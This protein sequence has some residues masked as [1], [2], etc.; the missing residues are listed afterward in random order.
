MPNDSIQRADRRAVLLGVI[1]VAGIVG[2][3]LHGPI[4]QDPAYHAFSDQREMLGVPHFWNVVSN[5]PFALAGILGLFVFSRRPRGMIAENAL[6]YAL[7]FAGAVLIA[8]GSS[9]YHLNPTNATLLW[10]RLPMTISLMA[11]FA[12]VIGE[13][14][15]AR[16][17]RRALIPLVAVGIASAA[18]WGISERL[19]HPDL[20]AYAIVQFLPMLLIPLMLILYPSRLTK[21]SLLWAILGCYVAAKV[22]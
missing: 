2:V 7:F 18:Y 12:I 6:A 10:D 8:V 4:T 15:D 21:V 17:A 9:Y 3:I 1:A 5:V 16:L 14:V 19:G 20:R 22:F 11:F 13:H